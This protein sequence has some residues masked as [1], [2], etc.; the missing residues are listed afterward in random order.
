MR[1]GAFVSIIVSS[2]DKGIG[3][4]WANLTTGK[5]RKT[6]GNSRQWRREGFQEGERV[7][8]SA[9]YVNAIR[10]LDMSLCA[11]GVLCMRLYSKNFHPLESSYC[12]GH[13]LC[14]CCLVQSRPQSQ[15][16]R[17]FT[18]FCSADM[19]FCRNTLASGKELISFPDR[20]LQ[21]SDW[22]LST[23]SCW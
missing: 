1:M 17:W 11:W 16:W 21:V 15:R 18:L 7:S 6:W 23:D 10:S 3:K 2:A 4:T 5:E 22:L 19:N 12:R 13:I 8:S 14:P 20:I 9:R